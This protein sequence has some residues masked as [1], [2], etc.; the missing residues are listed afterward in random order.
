MG[1]EVL[2]LLVAFVAFILFSNRRRKS[3]AQELEN[4]VKVGAKAVMLGGITGVVSEIRDTTVVIETVPGTKIEFLKAAVRSV[5]APSLDEK[6][7][8][9]KKAASSSAKKAPVTKVT[10]TK[11]KSTTTKSAK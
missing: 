3:A 10:S 9:A 1:F 4:S 11:A 8:V 5:E 6:P 2:F 7:A